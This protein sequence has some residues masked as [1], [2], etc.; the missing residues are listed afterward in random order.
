MANAGLLTFSISPL[1]AGLILGSL[2]F[3]WWHR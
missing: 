1:L 3:L 2:A